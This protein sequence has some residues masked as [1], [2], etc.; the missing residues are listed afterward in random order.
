MVIVLSILT[1]I[2]FIFYTVA[3]PLYIYDTDDWTYIS[4]SRQPWPCAE[5]WNPTK[6]L[7]ETL[8]P[9][10]AELGIRFIMPFSGDY[11]GSMAIAFAGML[12][13][14]IIAYVYQF[15]KTLASLFNLRVG[16]KEII[17]VI[18]LIYH[19]LPFRVNNKYLL[20]GGNVTCVFNYLIPAL[21]NA[22]IVMWFIGNGMENLHDNSF[23]KRGF[24]VLV[25]Y[26]A[27]NSNMFH[28]I[29]LAS[30]A[31]ANLIISF[32]GGYLLEGNIGTKMLL[33]Q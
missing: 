24:Y 28:S 15:G 14:F 27:I 7:P 5:Q 16:I 21:M 32:V 6:V 9:I 31:G 1:I 25:L 13:L 12:V 18:F 8:M 4:Y 2:L 26:L 11:I 17:S 29:I 22:T 33:K 19:F 30:F 3:H 20:Y 23:L 10:T